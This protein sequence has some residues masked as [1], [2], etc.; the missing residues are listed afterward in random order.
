MGVP[1]GGGGSV[2]EQ[3]RETMPG[4]IMDS[5][6]RNG[7]HTNHDRDRYFNG[8]NGE[9]KASE[10]GR[11]KNQARSESQQNM[12]PISPAIHN[13]M[14]GN[15]KDGS[16]RQQNSTGEPIPKDLL[17]SIHNL[18]PEVE[19]ITQNFVPL[20]DLLSRQ[21]QQSHNDLLKAINDLANMPIPQSAMNGS[22]SHITKEDDN[23]NDNV[24]KKVAL[25]DF[26]QSQHSAWVKQLVLLEW[27]RKV[28][29]V[30]KVIDLNNYLWHKGE[31]Y[32]DLLQRMN[33]VRHD[34][35]R[36]MKRNH[37]LATAVEVFCTG[38]ANFMPDVSLLL[39]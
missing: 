12:T 9:G 27:S 38:K 2:G 14:N 25:L 17:D 33:F 24:N 30:G 5:G 39:K 28:D 31:L 19:H 32:A 13:G 1:Q 26:V 37:D 11:D 18:P 4:V 6:S 16:T 20:S 3:G 34:G 15:L 10:K 21:S 29:E 36:G 22:S 35:L 23:S 7:S 8:I